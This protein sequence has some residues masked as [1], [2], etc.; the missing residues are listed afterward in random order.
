MSLVIHDFLGGRQSQGG[1]TDGWVG[2]FVKLKGFAVRRE[3]GEDVQTC[4]WTNQG[5]NYKGKASY[6]WANQRLGLTPKVRKGF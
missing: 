6:G 2:R 1:W 4:C 5:F 3:N